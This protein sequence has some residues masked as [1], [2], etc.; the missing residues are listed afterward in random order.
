MRG[1][2]GEYGVIALPAAASLGGFIHSGGAEPLT[3]DE[4]PTDK[5]LSAIPRGPSTWR[6]THIHNSTDLLDRTFIR[7]LSS[8]RIRRRIM[9]GLGV[10]F[11]RALDLPPRKTCTGTSCRRGCSWARQQDARDGDH[12]AGADVSGKEGRI[13]WSEAG[14][15]TE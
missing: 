9:A 2:L 14:E 13:H 6:T 5:R 10:A 7:S 1:Q 8:D 4:S 11:S 15:T 12:G 3:I